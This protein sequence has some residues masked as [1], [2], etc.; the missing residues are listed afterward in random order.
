MDSTRQQKFARLIQKEMAE[1]FQIDTRNTFGP[2][3]ITVT[4]VRVS[5][6]LGVAKIYVSLFP[7]KDKEALLQS[8]RDKGHELRRLLGNRI[9]HQVRVIPEL[10]FYLDDSLDYAERI[11]EL[12]K[13]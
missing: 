11:D 10:I 9:R 4:M 7:V 3:M 13:K 6:D 5:P 12:L 2:V 8:I 1:I